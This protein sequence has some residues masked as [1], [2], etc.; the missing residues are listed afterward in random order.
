MFLQHAP[1]RLLVT[2]DHVCLEPQEV[3]WCQHARRGSKD[4]TSAKMASQASTLQ[5]SGKELLLGVASGN[6]PTISLG[7]NRNTKILWNS[8]SHPPL[9]CIWT[10]CALFRRSGKATGCQGSMM[11]HVIVSLLVTA[12]L[13][14]KVASL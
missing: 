1:E 11:V 9:S 5:G 10:G 7:K 8:V 2:I 4:G 14:L 13:D 12:S 6:S 3:A